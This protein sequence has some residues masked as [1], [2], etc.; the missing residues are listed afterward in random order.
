MS[1]TPNREGEEPP[2][3]LSRIA[4]GRSGWPLKPARLQSAS[5]PG[6][7][8]L[9][10]PPSTSAP[11]PKIGVCS[12]RKCPPQTL[13]Q[14]RPQT[15]LRPLC[16]QRCKPRPTSAGTPRTEMSSCRISPRSRSTSTVGAK[17]SFGRKGIGTTTT[18]PISRSTWRACRG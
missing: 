10:T 8:A 7:M 2:D 15:I 6:G 12:R 3:L 16:K 14:T 18:I 13:V 4:R 11:S 9:A 17:S 5:Y 1:A